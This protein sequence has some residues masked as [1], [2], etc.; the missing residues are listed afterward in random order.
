[1]TY[2]CVLNETAQSMVLFFAFLLVLIVVNAAM[3]IFSTNRSGSVISDQFKVK[4]TEASAKLFSMDRT[5]A[6]YKKAI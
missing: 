5:I 4:S 3:L 2:F 6:R 1:M